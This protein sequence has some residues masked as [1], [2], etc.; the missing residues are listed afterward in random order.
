MMIFGLRN[1]KISSVMRRAM[2]TF[3]AGGGECR[4][5]ASRARRISSIRYSLRLDARGS[6]SA[7]S[8]MPVA[9]F[10][11]ATIVEPR[12]GPMLRTA[13]GLSPC[14]FD[15]QGCRGASNTFGG[16]LHFRA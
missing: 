10:L 5:A 8:T 12:N 7:R 11:F 2:I 15:G 4:P 6:V 3:S 14:E 9:I 16:P 1:L 13:I